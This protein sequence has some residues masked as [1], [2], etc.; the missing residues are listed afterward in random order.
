[1]APTV[2][3]ANPSSR[4]RGAGGGGKNPRPLVSRASALPLKKTLLLNCICVLYQTRETIVGLGQCLGLEICGIA[5]INK[6]LLR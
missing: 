5:N 2:S 3:K 1:M 6:N 4:F